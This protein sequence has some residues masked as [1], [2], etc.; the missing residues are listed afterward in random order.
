MSDGPTRLTRRT[1]LEI[2]AAT[3]AAGSAGV[4]SLPVHVPPPE[5]PAGRFRLL[6]GRSPLH[7]FGRTQNNPILADL[8]GVNDLWI[9]P[10]AAR[11]LGLRHGQDVMVA[12]DHGDETGPMPLKVTERMP[13]GSVYMVYGFGHTAPGLTRTFGKGGSDSEL[14]D[15]YAVDPMTGTT[16][17]RT[18]FVTVRAADAG[19]A[20]RS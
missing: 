11:A 1:F 6:Y 14:L 9:G 3:A 10:G 5:P 8:D 18:Q 7:S 17:M 19:K 20:R 12:N 16:G 15:T 13:D 4:P 2:A